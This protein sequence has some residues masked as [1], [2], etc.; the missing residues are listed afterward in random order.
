MGR[1]TQIYGPSEGGSEPRRASLTHA[2]PSPAAF[3]SCDFPVFI[4]PF[5]FSAPSF[6]AVYVS[7][8]LPACYAGFL[9]T[10]SLCPF[11]SPSRFHSHCVSLLTF[12]SFSYFTGLSICPVPALLGPAIPL[13]HC[14]PRDQGDSRISRRDGKEKGGSG[15]ALPWWA[16]WDHIV[17]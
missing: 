4:S 3:S 17:Y 5:F 14:H 15:G 10:L 7:L 12:L 6:A 2:Q 11:V 16:A 13:P 1:Q 9:L 8:T